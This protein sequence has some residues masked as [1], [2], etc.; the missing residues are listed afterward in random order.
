M[1]RLQFFLNSISQLSE[2]TWKEV[3]KLFT[4]VELSEN[5]FFVKE[6]NYA[7]KLHF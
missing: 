5:E 1:E 3:S 2:E 4:K 7:K 6:N